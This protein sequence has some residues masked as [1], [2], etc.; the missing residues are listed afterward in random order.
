MVGI[1]FKLFTLFFEP[2]SPIF[3]N[4]AF[5]DFSFS[6]SVSAAHRRLPNRGTRLKSVDSNRWT[7]VEKTRDQSTFLAQQE[8]GATCVPTQRG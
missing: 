5:T 7:Y 8:E 6:D 4:R 3:K 2:S 1:N